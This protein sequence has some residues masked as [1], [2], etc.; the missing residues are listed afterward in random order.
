MRRA[1][2]CQEWTVSC[3]HRFWRVELELTAA[4]YPTHG[5]EA[6]FPDLGPAIAIHEQNGRAARAVALAHDERR[7]QQPLP[8]RA[9]ARVRQQVVLYRCAIG[10]HFEESR[11]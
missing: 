10:Q 3:T 7:R 1:N 2:D 5:V 8:L 6:A 11:G 4:G 9:H